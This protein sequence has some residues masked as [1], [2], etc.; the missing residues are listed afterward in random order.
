MAELVVPHVR[1]MASFLEA[2]HEG[3]SRDN[4]RP[5][6]PK[7][8]A[9]VEADPLA[10][11]DSQL[12][13]PDTFVQPDGSLGQAMPW[14]ALWWVENYRFLGTVHVRHELN[15]SL[16][17]VG[18]HVGYAMRPSA[19]G[20]GHA[21]AALAAGLDWIRANLPLKRVL[22][23]VNPS[24]SHSIR[25]IQKNGGVHTQTV[26]HIWRPGEEAMH[27]WIEL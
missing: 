1:Y 17:R 6:T 22:L 20:Q 21:S 19:R 26:P 5:E 18:G 2:L 10:F 16:S 25:V 9:E 8:I 23:T 15:E 24:N 3:Y 27:F 11:L 13:P 4:L 14:T 7:S 12:N